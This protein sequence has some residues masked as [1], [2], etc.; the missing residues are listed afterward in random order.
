[1]AKV[2]MDWTLADFYNDG[3]TTRFVDRLAAVLGISSHRIKVVAIYEG[4]TVVD[5]EIEQEE[6]EAVATE[7]ENGDPISADDQAAALL[8]AQTKATEALASIKTLM[9]E[10]ATTGGLD[11]GA[12]V[13]GLEELQTDPEVKPTLLAGEPI[14]EPPCERT[15]T[16]PIVAPEGAI[17]MASL[18]VALL[19]FAMTLM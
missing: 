15:N 10:K 8:A 2:R 14:P 5:F 19:T 9:V 12:P 13:M 4:S 18:W 17:T 7:D 16:C 6:P 1:M 11:I 3:G